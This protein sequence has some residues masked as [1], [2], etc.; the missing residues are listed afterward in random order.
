MRL[1]TV[2]DGQG[3]DRR[4]ERGREMA[5]GWE[6]SGRTSE[7][8]ERPSTSPLV[9]PDVRRTQGQVQSHAH[10]AVEPAKG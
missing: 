10:P 1:D 4:R 8:R 5:G 9:T 6:L 3:V 7:E 2:A